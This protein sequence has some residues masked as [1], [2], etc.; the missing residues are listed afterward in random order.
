M[1]KVLVTG[2]SRGLGKELVK[3]LHKRSFEVIASARNIRDLD[4]FEGVRNISLDIS[5]SASVIKASRE[6]NDL[7]ILINNAAIS[8]S[9][10]VEI[11]DIQSVSKVFDVNVLGSIRMFQAFTPK[12]REKGKGLIVNISSGTALHSPPLQGVYSASKAALDR[13]CE[14]YHSEVKE[15]GISVMQIHS[16][17]IATEM[18]KT[19]KVY[20]NSDYEQVTNRIKKMEE[21]MI[22]V[23]P[24]ILAKAIVNLIELPPMELLIS[25]QD[26]MKEI[27][28]I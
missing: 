16:T 23:Q 26:L 27:K 15:F 10:A 20:S 14:A 17:G 22:G 12:M 3:E 8:I 7:D 11:V 24:E 18:R 9:G 13:I 4:K 25:V 1:K 6:I 28:N 21:N 5:D 19:Q 2:A